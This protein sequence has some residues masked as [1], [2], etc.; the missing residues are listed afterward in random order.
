MVDIFGHADGFRSISPVPPADPQTT[1]DRHRAAQ[2]V[3][4]ETRA[5]SP[6]EYTDAP[7]DDHFAPSRPGTALHVETVAAGLT[8]VPHRRQSRPASDVAVFSHNA[9]I[10]V[11]ARP[12]DRC[13][14]TQWHPSPPACRGCRQRQRDLTPVRRPDHAHRGA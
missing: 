3:R 14:K 6:A 4:T 12:P 5:A 10:T 7:A 1:G 11:A 8:R 2:D 9:A 13:I